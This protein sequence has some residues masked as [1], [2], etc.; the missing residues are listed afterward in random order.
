M[1]NVLRKNQKA[2]WIVIGVLC[3]PFV[4]YFSNSKVGPIGSNQLGR[5]YGRA[6]PTSEAQRSARLFTLARELGMYTLLQDM[7]TGAQ[8]ENDA[9]MEF[10]WNRLVLEHEA[11]RLGIQPTKEEIVKVVQDLQPFRG[12][13]GFDINKFNEFQNT[14]SS[15]GFNEAQ[16]E[17]LAGDQ[18][19]LQRVKEL[20][21]S[22]VQMPE[23]EAKDEYER[24]YGKLN[25]AVVR[26]RNEDVAN[27]LQISDDDVAK[28]Y[29]A[30]KETLKSDEKRKVS[31]V[32]FTL[33][34]EQKK[35]QG[36]ERMDVLQQLADR[37][38]DFTQALESGKDFAQSAAQFQL[39]VQTTGEFSRTAPDPLLGGN[40]QLTTAAFQLSEQEPNGRAVQIADGFD[41][42][43]LDGID[44]A[45]PLTLEEARPKI[46]DAIKK[47]RQT[48]LVSN[49]A[50]EV[51]RKIADAMKSGAPID[52]ALQQAGVQFEKLPPFALAD[53]ATPP[54]KPEAGKDAPPPAAPD[55]Q[56]IKMAVA[57]LNPGEVSPVTPTATGAIIAVLESRDQPAPEAEQ[58]AKQMFEARVVSQRK[59]I[60]FYEWL[61]QRRSEAGA[62]IPVPVEVA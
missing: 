27:E 43:H 25:V 37:A 5:I 12:Q 45:K 34:D 20:I 44:A 42:M 56:T 26:L 46:V 58:S 49:K 6:V 16:L 51:K 36:K 41:I 8:T 13:N 35:L 2:L 21:G 59:S 24:A 18:V 10:T 39:P 47:Q 60:A 50:A 19:T 33:N 57:E 22:S 54:A 55:L 14:L 38:N 7:V 48:E 31:F 4:F 30:H 28:Y 53:P 1:I 17:E 61:R 11:E 23:V 3:I 29:D 32:S 40:Q 62:P 9:I 15:L 52:A